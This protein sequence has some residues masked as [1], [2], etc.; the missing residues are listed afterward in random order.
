MES[1]QKD[2]K[3][4]PDEFNYIIAPGAPES[5]NLAENPENPVD[6]SEIPLETKPAWFP[7]SKGR[8][9]VWEHI[10]WVAESQRAACN[11]CAAEFQVKGDV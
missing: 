2:I 1:T 5:E 9:I 3:L 6:L 7:S 10:T 11:Y 4:E 8:S